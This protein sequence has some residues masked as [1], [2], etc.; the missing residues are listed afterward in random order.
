MK[1]IFPQVVD[2]TM[3]KS[4]ACWRRFG[5]SHVE[6]WKGGDE[7]TH[8]IAGAA[9]ASGLEVFRF[10]YFFERKPVQEAMIL[11]ILEVIKSYGMHEPDARLQKKDCET[12]CAALCF[13]VLKFNPEQEKYRPFLLNGEP[14]VEFSFAIPLP[15]SH[16]DTGQ[17]IIYAGRADQIVENVDNRLIYLEDDKTTSQLGASFFKTVDLSGQFTGYQWAAMEHGIDVRGTLIRPL[18]F[19][20]NRLDATEL[21]TYRSSAE[22]MSWFKDTCNKLEQAKNFYKQQYFPHDFGELCS[23]YGG[24]PY[25]D[26]CKL[27]SPSLLASQFEQR[28]WLPHLRKDVRI[29]EYQ[30]EDSK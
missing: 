2:N 20:E 22:I 8:L 24:C 30:L 17:P 1:M 28:V 14:T 11:G 3:I 19:Y 21:V 18:A 5:Y 16:P 15:I 23:S 13:Y 25:F 9:Y 10:Q 7:N 12:V 29:E 4:M 26:V 6:H 27:Q